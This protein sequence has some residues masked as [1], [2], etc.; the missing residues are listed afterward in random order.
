MLAAPRCQGIEGEWARPP[1]IAPRPGA[2]ALARP[3]SV[4]FVFVWP[5]KSTLAF[6]ERT[7]HIGRASRRGHSNPPPLI[8]I[9]RAAPQPSADDPTSASGSSL[10]RQRKRHVGAREQ[11][12]EDVRRSAGDRARLVGRLRR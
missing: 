8:A 5:T 4:D 1:A 3:L 6:G 7:R 11:L 9:G 2:F 12:G 10:S